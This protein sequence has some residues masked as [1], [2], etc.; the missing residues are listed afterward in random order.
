MVVVVVVVALAQDHYWDLCVVGAEENVAAEVV[1]V[2]CDWE[3]V[4]ERD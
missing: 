1:E 3:V 4:M 2:H